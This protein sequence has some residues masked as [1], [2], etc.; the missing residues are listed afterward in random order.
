MA[1]TPRRMPQGLVTRDA[2]TRHGVQVGRAVRASGVNDVELA[3]AHLAAGRVPAGPAS[4]RYFALGTSA[5]SLLCRI[6]NPIYPEW[7]IVYA[8]IGAD[9]EVSG[10]LV[11]YSDTTTAGSPVSRSFTVGGGIGNPQLVTREIEIGT[12]AVESPSYEFVSVQ[13]TCA[14]SGAYLHSWGVLPLPYLPPQSS[15]QV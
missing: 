10:T 7:A 2:T 14:T 8:L 13:I 12:G 4:M 3:I 9:D 11:A 6:A 5:R 1:N 15:G